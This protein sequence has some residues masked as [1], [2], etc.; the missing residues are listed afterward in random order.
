MLGYGEVVESVSILP[1]RL[2]ESLASRNAYLERQYLQRTSGGGGGS[3]GDL[4]RDFGGSG[5]AQCPLLHAES[6]PAEL[7]GQRRGSGFSAAE[8][9]LHRASGDGGGSLADAADMQEAAEIEDAESRLDANGQ[10]EAWWLTGS[11][12]VIFP[13]LHH[14]TQS[15]AGHCSNLDAAMKSGTREGPSSAMLGTTCCRSSCT[16]DDACM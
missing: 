6:A 11:M 13:A 5:P 16:G 9:E 14:E 15:T 2:Q 3:G 7:Q 8:L 1:H 10:P 4:A 12:Q